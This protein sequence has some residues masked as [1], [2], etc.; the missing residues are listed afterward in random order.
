MT[1]V[2]CSV[3][4]HFFSTS[5]DKSEVYLSARRKRTQVLLTF[6]TFYSTT[7]TTEH[8]WLR[9]I[10]VTYLTLHVNSQVEGKVDKYCFNFYEN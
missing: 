4:R 5:Q 1:D 9:A 7:T 2:P 6:F 10:Y 3:S 8:D